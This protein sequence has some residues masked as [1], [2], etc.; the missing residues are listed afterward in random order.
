MLN[1]RRPR[2]GSLSWPSPCRTILARLVLGEH[3]DARRLL[4]LGLGMAGLVALGWPLVLA[5]E[6]S[7]GLVLAF[8]AAMCWAAGTV[9]LKRFPSEASPLAFATWQLVIGAGCA[10][11]GMLVFEGVPTTRSFNPATLLAFS[12]HAV[13]GQALATVLWFE[14]VTKIPAST[15]ALG[16]L[17]VPAVGVASAMLILGER[18][19][20]ADHIGL[21]L[22]MAAA[23][24]VLLPNRRADAT[25]EART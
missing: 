16:T 18:P 12:Y 23:S 11:A 6:V 9:L 5:G 7:L 2:A 14:V 8:L 21:A 3:L 10:A 22:I 17:T 24:T 1:S 20:I 19:S 15:A 4:G 13:L 25:R